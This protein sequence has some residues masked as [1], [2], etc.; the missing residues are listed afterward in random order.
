MEH[1][2]YLSVEANRVS[3]Q[4]WGVESSQARLCSGTSSTSDY[5]THASRDESRV[6]ADTGKGKLALT[7]SGITEYSL[8]PFVFDEGD[9]VPS[10]WESQYG[11][12][13]PLSRDG[14][15]PVVRL[16]DTSD[17]IPASHQEPNNV[18]YHHSQETSSSS[19]VVDE[20]KSNLLAD[21]LLTA[22]K[23]FE[24]LFK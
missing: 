22:V 1:S 19:S 17:Y 10:K 2:P 15:P 16:S 3:S 6:E 5:V 13:K 12:I 8:D 7:N 20:D 9:S 18:E 21:C 11:S 23:V 24:Y 4:K 14:R